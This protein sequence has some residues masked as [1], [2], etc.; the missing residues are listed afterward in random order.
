MYKRTDGSWYLRSTYAAKERQE[1][2]TPIPLNIPAT[3]RAALASRIL[4]CRERWSDAV[5]PKVAMALKKI[6]KE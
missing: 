1:A 5:S 2:Y 4:D 3:T 6:L